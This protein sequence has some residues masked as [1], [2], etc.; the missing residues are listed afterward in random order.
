MIRCSYAFLTRKVK[1]NYKQRL[2]DFSLLFQKKQMTNEFFKNVSRILTI[3]TKYSF[4]IFQYKKQPQAEKHVYER[5]HI[6][7][8]SAGSAAAPGVT[9]GTPQK[10]VSSNAGDAGE[11]KP[12]NLIQYYNK[13]WQPQFDKYWIWLEMLKVTT[14]LNFKVILCTDFLIDFY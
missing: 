13:V 9:P 8:G 11:E 2:L 12:N 7:T 10:L 4:S 14:K 3:F 6:D 5:V 1:K